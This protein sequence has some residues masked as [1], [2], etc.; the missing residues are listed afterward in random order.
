MNEL[1]KFYNKLGDIVRIC[2]NV[3][4]ILFSMFFILKR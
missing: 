1:G 3:G 2:I 4:A